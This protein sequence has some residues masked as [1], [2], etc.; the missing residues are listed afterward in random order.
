MCNAYQVMKY[1]KWEVMR[2]TT[3][4]WSTVTISDVSVVVTFTKVEFAVDGVNIVKDERRRCTEGLLSNMMTVQ[5]RRGVMRVGC[6][7]VMKFATEDW[8]VMNQA[9]IRVIRTR[10]RRGIIIIIF[11]LPRR[12]TPL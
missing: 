1:A 5:F 6:Q 11:F 3:I 9:A 8:G 7:H 2:P 10:V 12:P 4:T